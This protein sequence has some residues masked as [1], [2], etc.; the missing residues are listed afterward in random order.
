MRILYVLSGIPGSG[1]TTWANKFQKSHKNTFIVSSDEIRKELTGAYQ[2]FKEENKVWSLYYSR[3]NEY[4]LLKNDANIIC[5]STALIDEYRLL[6]LNYKGKYD[7]K[8]LVYF[9][10]SPS[11]CKSRNEKR[12]KEKRVI[13]TVMDTMINSNQYPKE[14]TIK[15]FDEFLIINK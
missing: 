14:E 1:K 15:K 11:I 12:E 8:V 9:N 3:V 4:S 13:E 10:V 7:K 2:N 5:D 6:P